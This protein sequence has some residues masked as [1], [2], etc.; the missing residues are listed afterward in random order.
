MP[1][2]I[3]KIEETETQIVKA[4]RQEKAMRRE[5]MADGKIDPKEKKQLDAIT[6]KIAKLKAAVAKV[7]AEIE[8]ARRAFEGRSGDLARLKSELVE[9]TDWGHAD[10]TKVK[11]EVDAI[12][13]MT[14]EQQ[15]GDATA[16]LDKAVKAMAPV[17]KDT[18]A[19]IAAKA[20][21]DPL[22]KDF[23]TRLAKAAAT[24]PQTADIEALVTALQGK[25]DAVTKDAGAKDFVKALAALKALDA[26]IETLGAVIADT[27]AKKD[28]FDKAWAALAPRLQEASTCEFAALADLQNDMAAQQTEVEGLAAKHDYA[29]ALPKVADL[30]KRIDDY[31]A[32][33]AKLVD[34]STLYGKR[35]PRIE[36]ELGAVS[37]CEFPALTP[38]QTTLLDTADRMKA[39]AA[40]GDFDAALR[41]MDALDPL[42]EK[43]KADLENARLGQEFEKR[44][45]ELEPRITK[46]AVCN[47]GP[48]DTLSASIA[49]DH[50]RAQGS[51]A[52]GNYVDAL[53]LLDA[54][55]ARLDDYETQLAAQMKAQAE[56]QAG[57]VALLKRCDAVASCEYP[58][59]SAQAEAAIALRTRMEAA[60][61]TRDFVTALAAMKELDKEIGI[62]ETT[63]AELDARRAEYELRLPALIER[64][65]SQMVSDFTQLVDDRQALQ[66]KRAEME[67]AAKARDYPLAIDLMNAIEIMLNDLDAEAEKLDGLRKQYEALLAKIKDQIA[68]VEACEHKELLPKKT[69]IME[70]K[71]AM[72]AAAD[73]T[74][75]VVAMAKANALVP[76][77]T[78]FAKLEILVEDYARRLKVIDERIA[79]VKAYTYKSLKKK[80]EEIAKLYGEMTADAAKAE[81]QAAIDK[82]KKLETLV[83]ETIELFEKLRLQEAVYKNRHEE[84]KGPVEA[85][86][87]NTIKKKEVEKAAEEVGDAWE[88]FEDLGKEDEFIKA[89]DKVEA[90]KAAIKA[91]EEAVDKF[92]DA[93]EAYEMLSKLAEAAYA[94]AKSEAEGWKDVEDLQTAFEK[95]TDLRTEMTEAGKGDSP[96]YEAGKDKAQALIDAC[97]TFA[98]EVAKLKDRE[99]H[100]NGLFVAAKERFGRLPKDAEDK[101]E[102]EYGDAEGLIAKIGKALDPKERKLDRAA[103]LLGELNEKLDKIEGKLKT[104]DEHKADYEGRLAL[105]VPR[106][107]KARKTK[108]PEALSGDLKTVTDALEEMTDRAEAEDYEGG[109]AKAAMVEAALTTFDAAEDKLEILD[110]TLTERIGEIDK[111]MPKLDNPF[112]KL[113]PMVAEVHKNYATMKD[114]YGKQKLAEAE[115]VSK[116]VRDGLRA[117]LEEL[118]RIEDEQAKLKDEQI[119]VEK[120]KGV[121]DKIGDEVDKLKDGAID[122]AKEKALDY[123]GEKAKAVYNVVDGVKDA[124]MDGELYEGGKKIIQGVDDFVP[125]PSR[126][127]AVRKGI[128]FVEEGVDFVE[129]AVDVIKAAGDE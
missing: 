92:G 99:A 104:K 68:A 58:Q 55:E 32:E 73:E 86:K 106:V 48:L 15:W 54:I 2:K 124:V 121:L 76:L 22:R 1:F 118:E 128:E 72:F 67:A 5:F 119:K 7:R 70:L 78:E 14:A 89:V 34:A 90:V 80:Q 40:A 46:T 127:T 33:Y 37:Q 69:P 84:L 88:D 25:L 57:I 115:P 110:A 105:L 29:A 77:L 59:L 81:L 62:I 93:K 27:G 108:F 66:A 82:M 123:V 44:M 60:A 83:T 109:V 122:Y 28:E 39:A 75:Y 42:L 13:P 4:V 45:A 41:E 113:L 94:E 30:S 120:E 38:Q 43:F 96:D 116:T 74:D 21:Y 125:G 18:K 35:L 56:Y 61:G 6:D 3:E 87:K 126:I 17:I 97:K 19:Q 65:D 71:S 49:R 114:L 79:T 8:A 112:L 9:V 10:A 63:L 50:E 101:A 36:A 91:Y 95:L 23:D 117:A 52:A 103:E 129:K 53:T 12:A 20:V 31:M 102:D 107:D 111:D 98:G 11:T 51:A 47:F 64:F 85:I 16:Q 26:D 100:L 24:S